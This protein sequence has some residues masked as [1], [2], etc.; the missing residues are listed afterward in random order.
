MLNGFQPAPLYPCLSAPFAGR[1]V[2][3]VMRG[4]MMPYI[5]HVLAWPD[6][7]LKECR[8]M[9]SE[10]NDCILHLYLQDCGLC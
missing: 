8:C 4:C 9:P 3:G 10:V 7:S 5:S 2:R 6:I 1:K